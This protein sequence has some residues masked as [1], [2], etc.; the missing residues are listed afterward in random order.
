MS[1]AIGSSFGISPCQPLD[2]QYA[3]T[4]SG[5]V[6]HKYFF[7]LLRG[8]FD[9][10]GTFY[11]Y[12]DTRWKSSF[13]FYVVFISASHDHIKWLRKELLSRLNI[14]GHITHDYHKSTYQ[15][16]YGKKEG[17]KILK[18]MYHDS[19]LVCLGRKRLKIEKA[20]SIVGMSL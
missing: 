15:L 17:L 16:K 5:P 11:S 18:K 8:E 4:L 3:L 7:D 10:D 9:G 6:P 14:N 19:D 12:W 20:L 13:M 2:A 1:V